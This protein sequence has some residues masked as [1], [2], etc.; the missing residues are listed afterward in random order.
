M[1]QANDPFREIRE[2]EGVFVCQFR[3]GKVP[4]I[5]RHREVKA[6]AKDWLAYSS[7]APFRVPIPSEGDMRSVRQFPIETD[8]PE[9]T[10]Y[11]KIVEPFFKRPRLADMQEQVDAL[12]DELLTMA[13][14]RE[15][16]EF[17]YEFAIPLQSRALTYLLN[18]PESEAEEW[19]G[20]GMHALHDEEGN[21][22]DSQLEVY[23]EKQLDKALES[24]GEDLFSALTQAE[25][26]GRPLT[27]E[28]MVGF[29]NL[30][31]AGGRDTIIQTVANIAAYFA[32]HPEALETLRE[33]SANLT[34]ATEEFFRY[35]TPLGHI[36]RVCPHATNIHGQE[37]GPDERIALGWA[38]ANRD[39]EVFESPNDVKLDRKPNPHLAFGAGPHI[40]IGAIHARQLVR[41]FLKALC[42]RVEQIDVLEKNELV[43]SDYQLSRTVGYDLLRIRMHSR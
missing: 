18:V 15:S 5:L 14:G 6:A 2:K 36:G 21:P 10:E 34:A 28:E 41:R 9:H 22:K 40:C 17:V 4:M 23:I 16:I 30:T 33:D 12:I 39:P 42:H 25:F 32:D 13:L 38:S 35:I 19:I 11:R 7:D 27:R 43:T 26:Q 8:P 1:S 24:P 29:A 37:V 20:W 31:F 3:D